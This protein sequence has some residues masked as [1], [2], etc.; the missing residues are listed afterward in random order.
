MLLRRQSVERCRRIEEA[1]DMSIQEKVESLLTGS[2]SLTA[3]LADGAGS[4][5]HG[6]YDG[7][8]RYPAIV[9]SIVSDVPAVSS[10]N[11]EQYRRV[12]VRTHIVTNDG[13]Y[14]D[15]WAVLRPLMIDAGFVRRQANEVFFDDKKILVVDWII[16]IG[17]DE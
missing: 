7:A 12:T 13:Y 17:V 9:H 16:M 14:D 5:F 6:I 2:A 10:D 11:D 4:V 8:D 1:D 3:L 15:I